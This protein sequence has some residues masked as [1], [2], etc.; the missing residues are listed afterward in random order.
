MRHAPFILLVIAV[1]IASIGIATIYSATSVK[2]GKLWH[3]IYKRQMIWVVIGV[4]L[5]LLASRM[6]YRR[7]WDWSPILYGACVFFLVLVC[8]LG[9]TRLGAQRWLSFGWFNF[10]PSEFAKLVVIVF[11]ARYFSSRSV[12]DVSLPVS[13]FNLWKSL[14][15]PF[16]YVVFPVALIIEQPDLG[17]G[18]LIL[19]IFLT[20][21]FVAN[22][23][24][25]YLYLLCAVMLV[26]APLFWQLLHGYQKDRLLVFL[27]PNVDPLGAGYTVI[28][29]KIA[30]GSGGFFGKGWMSGTQSQLYFLPESHTDFI[31]ASY[32]EQ[33]GFLGCMLLF[34]LY[35]GVILMGAVIARRTSDPF[36]RIT[37]LGI[38]SMF[39]IQM[40]INVAMNMGLA[41]VVGVPLPLMSYGG[42]SVLVTFF[43][44]GVLASI[45]RRRTI[46]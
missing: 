40:V 35:Y 20:I 43:S 24:L 34:A 12:D 29:S 15:I 3:D 36:G 38:V 42:T 28:Q 37:A 4:L 18:L 27:N 19:F 10:Q 33:W 39:G 7:M 23:R 16:L 11:L 25:R 5:F 6:D 17:S 46:F 1:L 2:E 30:I 32:S 22:V 44:L 9:I 31:F 45:S 41:P 26:A 14:G 21:V 13:H 8:V